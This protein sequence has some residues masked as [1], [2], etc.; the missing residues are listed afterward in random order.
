MTF[1]QRQNPLK[2]FLFEY[3]FFGLNFRNI[4]NKQKTDLIEVIN[5]EF[6]TFVKLLRL[7]EGFIIKIIL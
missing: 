2:F 1:Y 3:I 7:F 6:V 4:L 5:L